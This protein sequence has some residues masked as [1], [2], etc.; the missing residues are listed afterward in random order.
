[1]TDEP[2]GDTKDETVAN[3]IHRENSGLNTAQVNEL[4]AKYGPNAMSDEKPSYLR[5]FCTG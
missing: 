2:N 5:R 4:F 1:M 3:K